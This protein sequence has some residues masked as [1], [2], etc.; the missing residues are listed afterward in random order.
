MGPQNVIYFRTPE[1]Y[2]REHAASDKNKQTNKRSNKDSSIY[3]A[4]QTERILS[5]E[6]K[7]KEKN[8]GV[9]NTKHKSW[10]KE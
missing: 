4:R 8:Y 6:K 5:S 9:K 2:N 3:I 1:N 10:N 7:T